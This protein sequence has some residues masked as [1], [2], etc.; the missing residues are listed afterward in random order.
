MTTHSFKYQLRSVLSLSAIYFV[1]MLG[2]F[3]ILPVFSLY[4]TQL[5]EATPSLIG[6]AL[7]AYGL[8]QA[9]CQIPLA[10]LS[11]RLGRKGVIYAGL[12]IFILG[13][14]VAALSHS[15]YGII[16]GRALQGAGAIGSTVIALAS[17]LTTVENRSKAMAIIGISI[18]VSFATA[19][20]VGPLVNN[21]IGLAGIFWLTALTGVL[22]ILL[23]SIVPK[24]P[25]L[26]FHQVSVSSW[27]RFKASIASPDL[28]RLN[29]GILIL[30]AALTAN[31][32]AIPILISQLGAS[33]ASDSW[34]IYLPA[35]VIAFL[36][37]SPLIMLAE[38]RQ[39][40]KT[41]FLGS[42][43]AL[44]VSQVLL[45]KYQHSFLQICLVLC[46]FFTAFTFLESVLPS[47]ISKI[48]PAESKGTAMGI[49]S[50][51][52]F[53]GIFLGG[54][55]GGS[56]YSLY[57]FQGVFIFSSLL[58]LAWLVYA[59]FMK[60]P[61]NLGT[62]MIPV[63]S[64]NTQ[65][66]QQLSQEYR[67]INGVVEAAIIVEEGMVYLKIDKGKITPEALLNNAIIPS[68]P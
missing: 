53:L 9:I 15:I 58:A 37:V 59:A 29:V 30:H 12:G 34:Q 62:V 68:P 8:T 44:L 18:G 3:I 66:A 17:D 52:Q 22:S 35:L 55:I 27:S 5:P 64:L 20:V 47:L 21:W 2:L 6:I 11:D 24:P 67:Q 42:I 63:G 32:I 19:I 14:I 49:Y 41:L 57:H 25:R 60:Q 1:R 65:Q 54:S 40:L 28:L 23:L 36:A 16:L 39:K 7:G 33:A 51:A 43:L 13:S 26:V 4:A 38:R 61:A 50:T 46:L 48:A 10:M 31:F 56:L 45:L